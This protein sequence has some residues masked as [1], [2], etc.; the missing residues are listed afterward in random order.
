MFRDFLEPLPYE[1]ERYTTESNK[2]RKARVL[3]QPGWLVAIHPSPM[4]GV[5]PFFVVDRPE[6]TCLSVCKR[7]CQWYATGHIRS[8][9]SC[10]FDTDVNLGILIMCRRWQMIETR[11]SATLVIAILWNLRSRNEIVGDGDERRVKEKNG[12]VSRK[13]NELM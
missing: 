5:S 12:G 9:E 2:A 1:A 7:A 6:K 4:L 8:T 3:P 10:S 11:V 13:G